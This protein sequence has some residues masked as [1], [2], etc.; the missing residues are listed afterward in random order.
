MEQKEEQTK[1]IDYQQAYFSEMDRRM[2]L[3]KQVEK[4]KAAIRSLTEILTD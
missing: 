2:A 1:K 3:E 4:L